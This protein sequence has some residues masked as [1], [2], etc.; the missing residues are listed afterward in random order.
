MGWAKA[1]QGVPTNE[2][3]ID[4][5]PDGPVSD[6]IQTPLGFHLVTILERSPGEQRPFNLVRDKVRQAYLWERRVDVINA[7]AR[8]HQVQWQ[9]PGKKALQEG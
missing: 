9:V 3:A 8:R 6:V 5:L 4:S 1:E 7:H 2:Q